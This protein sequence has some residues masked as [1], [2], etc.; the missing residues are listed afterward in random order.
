MSEKPLTPE[1]SAV[2]THLTMLQGVIS[3]MVKA[4]Q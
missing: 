3:R 2:Q 1:S 4:L